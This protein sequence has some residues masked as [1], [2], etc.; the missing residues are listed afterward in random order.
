MARFWRVIGSTRCGTVRH[1]LADPHAVQQEVWDDLDPDYLVLV[2]H[3]GTPEWWY[4]SIYP[5]SLITDKA[6]TLPLI[7]ALVGSLLVSAVLLTMVYFVQRRV[8][9][10]LTKLAAMAALINEKNYHGIEQQSV[11]EVGSYGEVNQ[12]LHAFQ[13]MAQ[14]FVKANAELE[15]RVDERTKE[16]REANRKLDALAHI[17]GLTGLMNR[18]ALQN[19]LAEAVTNAQGQCYFVMADIDD[20]KP[21]NDNYGH[22]A[23]D[24]ALHAFAKAFKDVPNS[25]T[26]RYGGEEIA[27][28]LQAESPEQALAELEAL[29]N[30]IHALAIEHQFGRRLGGVLTVS[31]GL[32]QIQQNEPA[33]ELI[34]RADKNMYRAKQAGGDAIATDDANDDISSDDIFSN[35]I[36][37]Q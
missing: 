30:A 15:Q 8:S 34:K 3:L 27:M 17:D 12:V 29:R 20:F 7:I 1:L 36:S 6:L 13:V 14:R 22:E 9:Q 2:Q 24:R 4:F 25:R 16:L 21:Y 31:V 5:K 28:L 11:R 26:Y 19:D 33:S 18:R 23:G 10:P 37:E 35:E 32:T